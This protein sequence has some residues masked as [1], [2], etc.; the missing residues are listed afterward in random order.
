MKV[1]IVLILF[2][3]LLLFSCKRLE[4]KRINKVETLWS[5]FENNQIIAKGNIIDVAE[6][7][8]TDHGF[9]YAAYNN[10][11]TINNDRISLG[12]TNKI[13]EF[14]AKLIGL[15]A[16]NIYYYRTYVITNNV[17]TYG[18]VFGVDVVPN[19]F[20]LKVDSFNILSSKQ[21]DIKASIKG[22]GGLKIIDFGID[23]S[24]V[25]NPNL[26]VNKQSL[27]SLN[28]D[29]NFSFTILNPLIDTNYYVKT[30]IKLNEFLLY[31]SAE[32]VLKVN[33]VKFTTDTAV[34]T[35]LIAAKIYGTFQ[36]LGADNIQEYGFCYATNTSFPT[37]NNS[38]FS[39]Q[40]PTLGSFSANIVFTNYGT[41]Y[42]RTYVI[43]D[44]KIIYGK[45]KSF[46]FN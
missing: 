36:N 14:S 41:Y 44:N 18:N 4:I 23:Y 20:D 42:Y 33:S 3:F 30:Y 32:K 39:Y 2:I 7:G 19:P 16:A 31:T 26:L 29:T 24:L 38:K 43:I 28:K 10:S 8:I 40:N 22:I 45:V 37:L 46:E 35:P 13:G 17:V 9:C 11:P 25:S 27:G 5:N 34:V 1:K 6:G 21:V 12:A 15:E